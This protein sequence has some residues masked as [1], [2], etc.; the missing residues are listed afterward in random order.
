MLTPEISL[1]LFALMQ[2]PHFHQSR[3]I[4]TTFRAQTHKQQVARFDGPGEIGNGDLMTAIPAPDIGQ[5][6]LLCFRWN[7]CPQFGSRVGEFRNGLDGHRFPL[8]ASFIQ[9]RLYYQGLTAGQQEPDM[10]NTMFG[11]ESEK[12]FRFS[13]N[14]IRVL[15]DT[16]KPC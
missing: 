4:T 9:V 16:P 1:Q 11:A 13:D 15:V 5:Q 3:H 12:E 7:G 10:T 6:Q 2:S 8:S 14:S